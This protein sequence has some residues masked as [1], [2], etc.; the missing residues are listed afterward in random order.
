[1]QSQLNSTMSLYPVGQLVILKPGVFYDAC[2]VGMIVEI[3]DPFD[4]LDE[5]GVCT[6]KSKY[7]RQYE[8]NWDVPRNGSD[9][10]LEVNDEAYCGVFRNHDSQD[11]VALENNSS[12]DLVEEFDREVE[13]DVEFYTINVAADVTVGNNYIYHGDVDVHID[14]IGMVGMIEED[15]NEVDDDEEFIDL[16]QTT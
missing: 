4:I 8:I 15:D 7:H 6:K 12:L 1:M 14:D 2:Y 3:R 13:D 16:T 10:G 11:F 9:F 5:N